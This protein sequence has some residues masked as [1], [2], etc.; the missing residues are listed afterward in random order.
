MG[1]MI[2]LA[3]E[4]VGKGESLKSSLRETQPCLGLGRK[5]NERH[6][7]PFK[8]P[9]QSVIAPLHSPMKVHLSAPAY[10]LTPLQTACRCCQGV[11]EASPSLKIW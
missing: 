1:R 8:Y 6:D 9:A 7:G 4:L 11:R 3:V 5:V 2:V 10:E